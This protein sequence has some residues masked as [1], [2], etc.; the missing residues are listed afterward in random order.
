MQLFEDDQRPEYDFFPTWM[1]AEESTHL[2]DA[3]AAK[4]P[5]RQETITLFGKSHLVPRLSV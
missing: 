4:S 2:Y 3:L 5:W 1:N